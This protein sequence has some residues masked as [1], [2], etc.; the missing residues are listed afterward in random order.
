MEYANF[1]F[2]SIDGERTWQADRRPGQSIPVAEWRQED[3]G[4]TPVGD[5]WGGSRLP[6]PF[7]A[8]GDRLHNA[9]TNEEL[10]VEDADGGPSLP[11]ERV[12]GAFPLALL[13]TV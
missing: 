6:V 11:L 2:S 13:H 12:L 10:T 5:V 7:A 4:I 3:P 1:G 9:F 8:P